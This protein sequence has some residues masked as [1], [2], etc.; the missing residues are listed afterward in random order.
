VKQI[1]LVVALVVL[2]GYAAAT[3][4]M[5]QFLVLSPWDDQG[6]VM[7]SVRHLLDGHRLY[8]D[9]GVYYGPLYYLV[10]W[11]LH[12]PLGIP[13]TYDVVRL[14]SFVF[15]MAIAGASACIVYRMTRRIML[16]A[17]TAVAASSYMRVGAFEP[18]HP[19]EL[20]VLLVLGLPFVASWSSARP[21]RMIVAIGLLVAS[22]CMVKINVG[23]LAGI[24]VWLALISATAVTPVTTA[25]RL[26]SLLAVF[27][28]PWMLLRDNLRDPLGMRL[29]SLFTTWIA[30]VAPLSLLMR[31]GGLGVP[32][33]VRFV[34]SC[35]AGLVLFL[36]FPILRGSS[37]AAMIEWL[38]VAPQALSDYFAT[39]APTLPV[40]SSPVAAAGLIASL[41]WTGVRSSRLGAPYLVLRAALVA[42][43]LF[44]LFIAGALIDYV[45]GGPTLFLAAAP[46]FAWL[47]LLPDP[48]GNE[49]PWSRQFPRLVLAWLAVLQPLQ[50]Y[51]VAG[52]QVR[53][54]TILALL[55]GLVSLGDATAWLVAMAPARSRRFISAVTAILV[56]A[57]AGLAVRSEFTPWRT[58]YRSTTPLDL[59][60]AERMHVFPEVANY[61]PPLVDHLH[62][63][64]RQVVIVPGAAS[65]YFWARQAPP[66]L[67]VLPHEM[68]LVSDTRLAAIQAAIDGL[69]GSCVVRYGALYPRLPPDP[70]V[71]TWLASRYRPGRTFGPYTVFL[72]RAD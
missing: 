4:Y 70:R 39:F 54:G 59:P 69:A 55:C 34:V 40:W 17:F 24:A 48:E 15:R 2:G 7:L 25:L 10:Q 43:L 23:L 56:L 31:G 64:C 57:A 26:G 11:V 66:T 28:L 37:A 72:P 33:L 62:D 38:I 61:L 30:T 44:G 22:A 63:V 49:R 5:Q 45:P 13:L 35:G 47:V 27:L 6:Y 1:A 32:H 50:V 41:S 3:A 16:V 71:E 51:P 18:G 67:D 65:L 14:T 36:L 60:G 58:L 46:A 53:C 42:K 9:V 12:G 52:S 68:Q 21:N 8:D 20:A 19:Q 29:A